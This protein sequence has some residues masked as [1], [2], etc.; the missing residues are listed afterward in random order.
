MSQK[1]VVGR[2]EYICGWCNKAIKEGEK[3]IHWK[4]RAPLF[5]YDSQIGIQYLEGRQHLFHQKYTEK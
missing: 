4:I 5:G 2:K 3:H 1:E